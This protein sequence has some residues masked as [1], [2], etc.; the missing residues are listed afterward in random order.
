MSE[1]K[2]GDIVL[3]K[4]QILDINDAIKA[5]Y[6]VGGYG[7]TRLYARD[8]YPIPETDKTYEDGLNDAWEAAKKVLCVDEECGMQENDLNEIFGDLHGAD[9]ILMGYTA[10]EVIKEIKAWKDKN[11]IHVGDIVEMIGGIKGLVTKVEEECYY[12]IYSDGSCERIE[13]RDDV[14]KAGRTADIS[15]YLFGIFGV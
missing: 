13:K 14:K 8:V 9:D 1:F 15:S 12:V 4:V 5:K 6:L 11:E 7:D 2:I 10:Q 3:A